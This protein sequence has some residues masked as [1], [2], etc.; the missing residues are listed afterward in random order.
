MAVGHRPCPRCRCVGPELLDH[1]SHD[2][3]I[4]YYRCGA[5]GHTWNVPRNAPDGPNHHRGARGATQRSGARLLITPPEDQ[6]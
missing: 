2:T 3:T 6:N 4:W 5:C 1:A